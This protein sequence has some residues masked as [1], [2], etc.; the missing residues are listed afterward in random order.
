MTLLCEISPILATDPTTP[1]KKRISG[2]RYLEAHARLD[3]V[4]QHLGDG[5][6]EGG[7]DFHGSLGF[8]ATRVNQ[9]VEGVNE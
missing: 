2:R 3:L 4:G 1:K 6:V 9:L 8:D 7:D 5:L